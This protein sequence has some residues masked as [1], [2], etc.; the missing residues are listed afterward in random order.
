M[1]VSDWE[2][3]YTR[4]KQPW[5]RSHADAQLIKLIEEYS[6]SPCTVLDVGCGKGVTARE[7]ANRLFKVK[8]I[9]ISPK[10]I[11]WAKFDSKGID[12][13]FEVVDF[14]KTK[15][16]GRTYDLITD[17]GCF[18]Y[19]LNRNFAKKVFDHL[20]PSGFW[21]TSVASKEDKN[22][23]PVKGSVPIRPPA[24][25]LDRIINVVKPYFVVQ[26]IRHYQW[27]GTGFYF[28]SVLMNKRGE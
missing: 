11:E 24:H 22:N 13:E 5:H 10:A 2:D 23:S 18:H 20:R 6:I 14:L 9:D 21:Y 19:T 4:G 25:S 17:T 3:C 28:Y 8:G 16:L 27:S 15:F 12:I 26:D 1:K 7:L